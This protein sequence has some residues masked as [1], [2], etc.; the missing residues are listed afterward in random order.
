MLGVAD[1]K[2]S[3]F[4]EDVS[5]YEGCLIHSQSPY[6]GQPQSITGN[7]VGIDAS[8]LAFRN[9]SPEGSS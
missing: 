8:L 7:H 3:P 6:V 5:A 4:L 1:S 9:D 2:V